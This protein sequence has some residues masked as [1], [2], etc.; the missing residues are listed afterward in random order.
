MALFSFKLRALDEE[1][2]LKKSFE[3]TSQCGTHTIRPD[4]AWNWKELFFM[5][6][7]MR[8]EQLEEAIKK[9]LSPSDT[10]LGDKIYVALS[11]IYIDEH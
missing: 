1:K 3:N 10:A 6:H 11:I 7:L 8:L 4:N 9:I 5:T 2:Q